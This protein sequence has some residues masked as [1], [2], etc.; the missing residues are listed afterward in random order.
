MEGWLLPLSE[1]FFPINDLLRRKLQTSLII[2]S[3]TLCVASTLFLLLFSDKIGFGISLMAEGTLTAGFSIAL[4]RFIIFIGILIFVIGAL[5]ISFMVFVMMSQRVRDIGLM[6]AAGCPNDLIFGYFMNEL[7]IVIFIGCFLGV[8]LG[9]VADFALTNILI[10]LKFQVSQNPINFWIVLL[11]FALYFVLALIFGVKPILDTTKI[12]A[13]KALSP[14]YYLGISKEPGFK[15]VS[16][17]ALTIKIALRS[18]FRRKLATIRILLCLTTV[19]ILVT[20]VVAGG[21]IADQTTKSW[22][23]KA[24]GRDIVVIAHQEMCN[25]YKLLLSKFHKAEEVSQFNYTD[26]KYL[27]SEE[28]LN[29]LNLTPEI[30]SVNMRLI[31]EAWIREVPGYILNSETGATTSVGDSR[32]GVSLIVGVEPEKVLSDWFLD[33]EFLKANKSWEAVIGDSVAHKMFTLPLKQELIV[34]GKQSNRFF[35]VTGVCV[36]PINNGNVTYVPLKDLQ[37]VTGVSKP[38][39]IMV[40]I[41]D[42]TNRTEVLNRIR[43]NV[44][45]VNSDYEV[46]ELDEILAENIGFLSYVWST[47]MFLPFFSLASASLCLIC[48]I[49]LIIAEQRQE[50][51]VLRALGAKPKTVLKIV[52]WQSLVVLLSSYALGMAFGVIATLLILV[53]EPLVTSFTIIEIAVWLLMALVATFIFSLYPAIKFSK[54]PLLEIMT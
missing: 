28:L 15:I 54:K 16:K 10:S 44:K 17:S 9:I 48:Y 2:I 24:I 34:F 46:F 45:K 6:K 3:L 50:F 13:A 4:S 7:L 12:E 27:L 26:S 33:G 30:V 32:E 11:V 18:L 19:F 22:V 51:G 38:N 37:N 47:I 43:E 14:T 1:T 29:Q 36:D 8:V 25:Q 35:N 41:E 40:K 21:I 49:M 52:S 5:L 53:P 31:V 23:E 42:S 39:I 20:V